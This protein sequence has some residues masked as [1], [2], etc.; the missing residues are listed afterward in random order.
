MNKI[1]VIFDCENKRFPLYDS[2]SESE[3]YVSLCLRTKRINAYSTIPS[4]GVS[5]DVYNGVEIR[6]KVSNTILAS[7]LENLISE[8]MPFFEKILNESFIEYKG[9][10]G[11]CGIWP[12]W[13]VESREYLECLDFDEDNTY[14]F[15]LDNHLDWVSLSDFDD[16]TTYIKETILKYD[17]DNLYLENEN[18]TVDELKDE[19]FDLFVDKISFSRFDTIPNYA[20]EEML[21]SKSEKINDEIREMIVDELKERAEND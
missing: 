2:L 10:R 12:D 18:M 1:D 20:L 19:L 16:L 11:D 14:I 15:D 9:G 8:K 4:S 3:A 17:G 6:F 21:A 5:K 7:N 13:L